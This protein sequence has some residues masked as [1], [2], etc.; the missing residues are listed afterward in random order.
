MSVILIFPVIISAC[1]PGSED[2]LVKEEADGTW[3]L[4]VGQAKLLIDPDD[5]GKDISLLIS[6]K[7]F[8]TGKDI[9]NEYYGNSLWLAPQKEYWPEPKV[10]DFE[11]YTVERL[12]NGII[13]TSQPDKV[14][15]FK[16]SKTILANPGKQ[17]FIHRYSITNISDSVKQLAAWEVT[18]F[19][20]EGISLFP[21]GDSMAF[22]TRY[23]DPSIP[24][25]RSDGIIWHSYDPSQKGHPGKGSKAIMDG[26]DGWI[27]YL[28]GDHAMVKIFPDIAPD[29]M[30]QGELDVEI[31]VD[32]EFEYIEIEVLSEKTELGLGES[33]EWQVE[34]RILEIP[35]GMDKSPGS[36]DLPVFIQSTLE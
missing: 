29:K 33:L 20:K 13:C 35:A 30:V 31:Y 19:P 3:T 23:L 14:N 10:L 25:F 26:K 17:A 11:P 2:G 4:S 8:L 27:A 34:W 6:G 12:K 15:G 28:L 22:G 5:G 36:Q 1:K 18:R 7:E 24:M 9:R 32:S 16:Y 21:A